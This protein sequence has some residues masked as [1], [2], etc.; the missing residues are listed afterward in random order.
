MYVSKILLHPI[1][2]IE[3]GKRTERRRERGDTGNLSNLS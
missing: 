3:R 1:V 2:Q